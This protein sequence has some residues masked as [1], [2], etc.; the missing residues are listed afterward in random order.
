MKKKYLKW[1]YVIAWMIIIF[2]FSSQPGDESD[3]NSKLVLY[4]FNA[5]G[6]DLNTAFGNLANFIVRKAA[7]FTEYFILYLLIFNALRENLSFRKVLTLSIITVFFYS[8]SDEFHQSFVPGRGPS[9]RD[10]L[11]DTSGGLFALIVVYLSRF[12][13]KRSC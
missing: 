13:N 11:I 9:F 10:V 3:K 12:F 8:A 7:H 1:L 2:I 6:L 5:L 4:V